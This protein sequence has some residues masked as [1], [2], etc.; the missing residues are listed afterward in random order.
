MRTFPG[1]LAAK[2]MQFEFIIN[3]SAQGFQL[4]QNRFFLT[5]DQLKQKRQHLAVFQAA[6]TGLG[7]VERNKLVAFDDLDLWI[8]AVSDSFIIQKLLE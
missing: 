5:E 3:L 8:I 6:P 2:W 7:L 4:L 1:H